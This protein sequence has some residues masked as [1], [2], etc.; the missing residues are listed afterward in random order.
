MARL[1]AAHAL[2]ADGWAEN[3][4][5]DIAPDGN[6]AEVAVGVTDPDAE[7]LPGHLVPGM[8]DLHSH[9]FQ[10]AMAGLAQD[11]PAGRADFWSWRQR[12]YGIARR[13]TP[14]DLWAV[15]AA[16]YIDLLKG[17]YTT[18]VE[19]HYL[20]GP[21][22]GGTYDDP[23]V[24]SFA[25]H[26][27]AQ[28]AGI[29]LTLAPV[30]YARPGIDAG[31]PTPAQ[32]RFI[33][34]LDAYGDIL[35]R[36]GCLFRDDRDRRIA[37]AAHSLRGVPPERLAAFTAAVDARDPQAPL[38][39]HVAEQPREVEE[40]LAA[41][42]ARPVELLADRV[43]LGPRW[44]LVHA[45]HVTADERRRIASSGAVAGLCPSTEADLGDGF[46][47]FAEYWREEGGFG[48]G[49]DANLLTDAAG[50]LRLLEYGQRLRRVR[51]LVATRP[52]EPHCGAA[53]YRAALAGGA[54]AAGRPV[55]RIAPG[56]RAD[57]VH[58]DDRHPL[59]AGRRG[60]AVLDTFVFAGGSGT[61][62]RDVM[63]GGLWRVRDGVHADEERARRGLA[64][65][66]TRLLE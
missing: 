56:F 43:A 38:H 28:E 37:A 17:G 50:E 61:F 40:C 21:P 19:F 27:A 5:I 55:G 60:D 35:D 42:G 58:L 23:A 32:R 34:S 15:A 2:L 8:I 44:C 64:A 30:W 47:P 52:D 16:L 62:V 7:R 48:I 22:E 41:Y 46:F 65:S 24:M 13:F 49:S 3:V 25:L 59:L 57:L 45:T 11:R 31:E 14:E 66:V 39:I 6:I 9:A 10:R 20:H 53:L 1:L 51:R 26:E 29:A 36:V 54:R 12:M 4:A 63:V 18:V 33:L